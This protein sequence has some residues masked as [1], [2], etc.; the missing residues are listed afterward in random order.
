MPVCGP[1]GEQCLDLKATLDVL[2][3]T[4]ENPAIEKVGQN[5]K[6]DMIVLRSNGINLAA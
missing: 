5:L 6:Y 2:R 1:A 3:P 4:L